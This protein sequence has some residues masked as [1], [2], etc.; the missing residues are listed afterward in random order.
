[1]FLLRGSHAKRECSKEVNV[2]PFNITITCVQKHPSIQMGRSFLDYKKSKGLSGGKVVLRYAS[3]NGKYDIII[4]TKDSRTYGH[5]TLF[6]KVLSDTLS[7]DNKRYQ[8]EYCNYIVGSG[9]FLRENTL[10]DYMRK[11]T[12]CK[13]CGNTMKEY[14]PPASKYVIHQYPPAKIDTSEL[15]E[16]RKKLMTDVGDMIAAFH[17]ELNTNT[18]IK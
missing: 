18:V 9:A 7:M 11:E 3:L 1:V 15:D 5:T 16:F 12:R 4:F 8:C 13:R 14:L 6:S 2:P 17:E 10:Y